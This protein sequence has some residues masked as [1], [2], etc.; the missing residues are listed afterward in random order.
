MLPSDFYFYL[1]FVLHNS[2]FDIRHIINMNAIWQLPIG[3][4]HKFL[5]GANGI[6]DGIIGGWQLSSI[7]RWNSGLPTGF[8]G[9]S[10]VFDDARWAT[11]WNVQSNVT[12]IK[13]IETCPT[14]GGTVAP[15]LFG[16]NTTEAYRS[17]RNAKPGE[18]GDRNVF[19]VPGYVD[20][21]LGL[22]KS[23]TMPWSENHKLQVRVEAFNVTNTQRLGQYDTSR[24]GFGVTLN[25]ATATPPSQWSNFTAIQ[26]TPRVMQ[27]GFRYEF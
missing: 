5:G 25:P 9:D 1:H 16:C 7:F 23:F 14:R 15:K 12:R 3:K 13:P 8:Y 19:R 21:D 18:T 10:G 26:G 17:F 2:D 11:N 4:G 24:G 6:V 27:F 22:G 20:L